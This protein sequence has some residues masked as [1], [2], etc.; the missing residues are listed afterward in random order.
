MFLLKKRI[1]Y[2]YFFSFLFLFFL[3]PFFT[4][5]DILVDYQCVGLSF[6]FVRCLLDSVWKIIVTYFSTALILF[7]G[8]CFTGVQWDMLYSS[9]SLLAHIQISFSGFLR[10][11]K[12]HKVAHGKNMVV[13]GPIRKLQVTAPEPY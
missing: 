6:P 9:F 4:I 10:G 5:V 12:R 1:K 8:S 11:S 2:I 7:S 3:V 13:Q